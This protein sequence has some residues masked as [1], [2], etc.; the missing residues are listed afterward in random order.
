MA[1]QTQPAVAR[2][3]EEV[4]VPPRR[5][6]PLETT[7]P[8]CDHTLIH[9]LRRQIEN[10]LGCMH[11]ELPRGIEN[12]AHS[13]FA[14]A[15]LALHSLVDRQEILLLP[16]NHAR[17]NGYFGVHNSFC[18]KPF[19][20]PPRRQRVMTGRLQFLV[21][22]NIALDKSLEIDVSRRPRDLLARQ[23][24]IELQKSLHLDRPFQM[25]MQLG[26]RPHC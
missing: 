1:H 21:H 18:G 11:P 10:R 14:Q 7:E 17:R 22:P 9:Q 24:R 3:L 5:T 2:F 16:Q 13:N 20:Q 4:R 19:E 26:N 23:R 25:Q 12:P 6:T 8:D 15:R